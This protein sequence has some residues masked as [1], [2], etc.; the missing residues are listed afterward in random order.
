[1]RRGRGRR[2]KRRDE[3]GAMAAAVEHFRQSAIEKQHSTLTAL[4]QY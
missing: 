2:T 1:M 4:T 3:V